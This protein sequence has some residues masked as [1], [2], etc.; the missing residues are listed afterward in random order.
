MKKLLLS[1]FVIAAFWITKAQQMNISI[2]GHTVTFSANTGS[3]WGSTPMFLYAYVETTDTTPA[4]T[5]TTQIL[6]NWPGTEMT[7]SGPYSVS[8]DLASFFSS[9]TTINNI[10]FIYN[11][12]GNGGTTYQNPPSGQPGFSATDTARAIGWSPV[13]ISTLGVSDILNHNLNS[14]VADGQLIT[15]QKGILKLTVYDFGGKVIK[16]LNV[17]NT[18]NPIDLNVSQKGLYLVTISNGNETEVVKFAR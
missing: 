4:G 16:T 3:D 13:T 5:T 1:F 11:N 7:G 15:S 18:G 6:G 12:G 10:K 17:K 8:V 14:L 2:S 9:G